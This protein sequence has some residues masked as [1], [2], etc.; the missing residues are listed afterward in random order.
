MAGRKPTETDTLNPKQDLA[1]TALLRG[2]T[3]QEAAEAAGVTRQTVCGWRNQD[4]AFAAELNSRRKALWENAS[5]RMRSLVSRALEVL[6]E[7]LDAEDPRLRQAAAVHVLR[8][9][10]LYGS[11]LTPKGPTQ[12]EL[13]AGKWESEEFLERLTWRGVSAQLSRAREAGGPG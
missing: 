1:L 8:S 11:D 2:A 5:E 3:D 13:V 4:A 7:D 10:G 12:P 9:V 6:C